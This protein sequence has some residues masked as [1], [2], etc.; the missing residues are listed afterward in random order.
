MLRLEI[1][2]LFWFSQSIFLM[3]NIWSNLLTGSF[4]YTK[5][6]MGTSL[7]PQMV[8]TLPAMQEARVPSLGLEDPLEKGMA[9]HSNILASL[10]LQWAFAILWSF[11]FFFFLSSSIFSFL[12]FIIFI[13]KPII[14][15]L[16]LLLCLPFL[17]FFSPCR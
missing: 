2:L 16:H 12:F 17:L 7:V 10:P 11:F 9:T 4:A 13:F 6:I 1:F 15:F 14:F 5:A 3:M 8:K